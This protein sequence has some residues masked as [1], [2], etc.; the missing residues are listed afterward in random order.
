VVNNS[1]FE[2]EDVSFFINGLAIVS[3]LGKCSLL[4]ERLI[5]SVI[6]GA[7]KCGAASFGARDEVDRHDTSDPVS[8]WESEHIIYIGKYS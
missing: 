4:S 7:N 1:L 2:F 5:F 3:G 6:D 8:S